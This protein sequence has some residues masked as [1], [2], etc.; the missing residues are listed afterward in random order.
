M[1]TIW[2]WVHTE[3]GSQKFW[4]QQCSNLLVNSEKI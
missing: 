1:G 4:S 2:T 3:L